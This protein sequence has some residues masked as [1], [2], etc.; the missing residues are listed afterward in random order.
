M[1]FIPSLQNSA[2]IYCTA[3][4][5]SL[6]V[7][8]PS[9]KELLPACVPVL[10]PSLSCAPLCGLCQLD[11]TA[12]VWIWGWMLTP[13]GL[14]GTTGPLTRRQWVVPCNI[15]SQ[16]TDSLQGLEWYSLNFTAQ[17][18]QHLIQQSVHILLL[19]R[20]KTQK[21]ELL[22]IYFGNWWQYKWFKDTK[23]L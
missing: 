17:L 18:W 16:G 1:R 6:W 11:A 20:R 23:H 3:A 13:Q 4:I 7:L 2:N 21:Q 12:L 10:Y 22:S 8:F 9:I 15:L 5:Y 14:H 19:K